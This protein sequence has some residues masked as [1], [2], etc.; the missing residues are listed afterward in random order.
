MEYCTVVKEEYDREERDLLCANG[1]D[2]QVRREKKLGVK[3]M[4]IYIF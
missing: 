2:G 4:N 1:R 3:K